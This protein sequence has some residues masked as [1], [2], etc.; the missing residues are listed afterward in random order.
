MSVARRLLQMTAGVATASAIILGGS[1]AWAYS[2]YLGGDYA[3]TTNQDKQA[4]V[5]DNTRNNKDI[6]VEYYRES[7]THGNLWNRGDKGCSETGSGTVVMQMR[8]CEQAAG[9]D[10][11]GSWAYRW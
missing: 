2:A 9:P 10:R 1:Q 7:G 3:I 5:C 6:K 8:V 11:C 4:R